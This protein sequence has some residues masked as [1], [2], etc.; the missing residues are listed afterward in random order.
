[1]QAYGFYKIMFYFRS[2]GAVYFIAVKAQWEIFTR[3]TTAH[4]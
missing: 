4:I 2:G 1:M 3:N